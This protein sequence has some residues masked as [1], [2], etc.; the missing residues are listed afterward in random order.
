V[1][2]SS[3]CFSSCPFVFSTINVLCMCWRTVLSV[4]I[5]GGRAI[6]CSMPEFNDC[7]WH[8]GFVPVVLVE[9][10]DLSQLYL[11]FYQ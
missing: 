4:T 11:S 9:N 2:V 7:L 6:Y 3:A 5:G 8:S 1:N 10:L